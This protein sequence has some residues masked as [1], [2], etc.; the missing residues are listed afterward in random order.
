MKKT[1]TKCHRLKKMNSQIDKQNRQKRLSQDLDG[2]MTLMWLTKK[3]N[4]AKKYDKGWPIKVD[5]YGIDK[6]KRDKYKYRRSER[7]KTNL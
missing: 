2:N 1:Q 5:S 3:Q 4:L 6:H 7:T